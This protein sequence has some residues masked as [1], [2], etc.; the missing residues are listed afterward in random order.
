[1]SHVRTAPAAG[2]VAAFGLSALALLVIG[3]LC[4]GGHRL[5]EGRGHHAYDAGAVAPETVR[6]TEGHN[7]ELSY[8]GGTGALAR[9][10]VSPKA[11]G[12]SYSDA[13]SGGPVTLSTEPEPTGKAVDVFAEFI[14]PISG[15]VHI[16]C[17]GLPQVFVDDADNA[18][19]DLSGLLLLC[20][21]V[22]LTIGGALG[23]SALRIAYRDRPPRPVSREVDDDDFD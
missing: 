1:M 18:N 5:A 13:D 19:F 9:L 16:A 7:Y 3:V 6:L 23:L 15:S 10:G 17:S 8:P 14:S 21:V 22:A 12:C 20:A 2:R 4:W 11:P